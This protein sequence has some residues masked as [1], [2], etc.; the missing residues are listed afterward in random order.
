MW[1]HGV[2]VRGVPLSSLSSAGFCSWDPSAAVGAPSWSLFTGI[3]Y[4]T[5]QL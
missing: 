1:H 2:A 3:S 5:V 4:Q